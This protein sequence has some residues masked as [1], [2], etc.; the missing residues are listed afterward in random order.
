M[1]EWVDILRKAQIKDPRALL[2]DR[3]VDRALSLSEIALEFKVTLPTIRNYL[4]KL[5]IPL[6]G[7]GGD[8]ST[9]SVDISLRDY[10]KMTYVELAKKYKV[11]PWTV[12]NRTRGFPPKKAGHSSS[13]VP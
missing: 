11:S 1:I 4:I 9:K 10:K 12:W 3:Y 5:G 2:I 8:N 6:R 7:R 13:S